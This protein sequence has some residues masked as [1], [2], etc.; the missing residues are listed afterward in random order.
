MT[1][2]EEKQEQKITLGQSG[3][4]LIILIAILLVFYLCLAFM[5]AMWH[6]RFSDNVATVNFYNDIYHPFAL[7]ADGGTL[8]TRPWTIFTFMF[9][10][11]DV[12]KVFANT[13][14]ITAFAYLLQEKGANKKI[15]PIFIYSSLF[16][17]FIFL[18]AVNLM[19]SMAPQ[20]SFTFAS[21]ASAGAMGLAVC[22]SLLYPRYKI[23]PMIGG[24]IPVWIIT[25]VFTASALLTNFNNITQLLL[26]LGGAV[27]GLVFSMLHQKGFDLSVGM[28]QLFDWVGNLFNPDRP[29]GGR[30]LKDELFYNAEK[31]PYHKKP[32]A[33]PERIDAILD[34]IHQQGID[35]LTEEEKEILKRAKNN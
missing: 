20:H 29:A 13:L 34:K 22:L 19:P 9:I 12:W 32:N 31:P 10:H 21:G 30:S 7:S 26:I 16:A 15:I 14:W 1:F 2:A 28:N 25:L 33:T 8:L 6:Y 35:A 24:G 5:R 3:N 27:F 4:Q 18:L 23:F 17:G 11:D